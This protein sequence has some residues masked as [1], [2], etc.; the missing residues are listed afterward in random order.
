MD[1]HARANRQK[2]S[3]IAAKEMLLRVHLVPFARSQAAGRDHERGRAAAQAWMVVKAPKTV[4]NVSGGAQRAAEE[5]RRVGR[6]RPD[7]VHDPA[8]ADSEVVSQ[9]F[10]ISTQYE[11]LV[12]A[13][14]AI[15]Q[16][17]ELIVLLGGEAG[18]RCGEM[19]AL[20]WSDVDLAKAPALRPAIGLERR[21]HVTE[22][23]AAALRSADGAT[24]GGAPRASASARPA[25]AV[26]GRRH[27]V[28]ATAGPVSGQA[29]RQ[30]RRTSVTAFTSFAT[31]S[32]RTWRCVARP[33]GRFRNSPGTASSA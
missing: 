26:S 23:R 13:A 15:D 31:R 8:A 28:D 22:G 9:R 19:I 16:V 10:T 4:N 29:R 17:T 7:A 32:V 24:D 2:P 20:E 27:A 25:G 11:R 14:K 21:G 6:H 30:E 1:G 18:L 5:S 12:E 3:G 33:R